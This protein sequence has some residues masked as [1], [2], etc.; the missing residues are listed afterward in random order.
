MINLKN[1]L[2]KFFP[3]LLLCV[4]PFAGCN[5]SSESQ[6]ILLNIGIRT[7]AAE[8]IQ[9]YPETREVLEIV[10][11]VLNDGVT[12]ES[13]KSVLMASIESQL[14]SDPIHRLAVTDLI[15]LTDSY[16]QKLYEKLDV[17]ER[18]ETS[19]FFAKGISQAL[20]LVPASGDIEEVLVVDSFVLVLE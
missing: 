17:T 2:V 20:S 4:L 1:S 11:V 15:S 9:K 12:V 8:V 19:K 13:L 6:K 5:T 10:S 18:L 7:A 3:I 16:W 14:P